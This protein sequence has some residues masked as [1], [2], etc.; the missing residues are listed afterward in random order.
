LKP[1]PQVLEVCTPLVQDFPSLDSGLIAGA[2]G[3]DVGTLSQIS[4]FLTT[5]DRL[6][7]DPS[8]RTLEP[9]LLFSSSS[10][11]GAS[12]LCFFKFFKFH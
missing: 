11:A 3:M 4:L 2:T 12:V 10:R 9:H 8:R 6:I 7:D 1:N 5:L